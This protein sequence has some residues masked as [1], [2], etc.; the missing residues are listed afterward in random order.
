MKDLLL[1]QFSAVRPE[2]IPETLGAMLARHRARLE[3]VLKGGLPYTWENLITPLDEIDEEQNRF[4]SPVAH[5]HGTMQTPELRTAYEKGVEL[6]TAFS[7]EFYQNEQLYAALK[8]LNE[9]MVYA[10]LSSE[11][12]KLLQHTLRDFLL[13][14]SALLGVGKKRYQEISQRL[15]LLETRFKNNVLDATEA[16]E[17]RV[18]DEEALAGIPPSTKEAMRS[19]ALKKNLPGWTIKLAPSMFDAVMRHADSRELRR[20]MRDAYITRASDRGPQAGRFDN[21]AIIEEILAL[22]HEQAKLLGFKNFAEYSLAKK[23]APSVSHVLAFLRDLVVRSQPKALQEFSEL[24]NHARRDGIE[25]L[26]PW[27]L[28]YYREKVRQSRFAFSEEEIRQYFPLPKVLAGLFAVTEKLY[29]I[30]IRE[31][32]VADRPHHDV[33]LFELHDDEGTLVGGLWVDLYERLGQKRGGAWMGDAVIRW[34]TRE[35]IQK[36]VAYLTCNFESPAQGKPSLLTSSDVETL[37]HEFGHCLNH[38]LTKVE[39][40]GVSGITGVEWDAVELPSQIM[41]NWC[42]EEEV[43]THLISGHVETGHPLPRDLNE[44]MQRAKTFNAGIDSLRQLLFALYD[45]RLHAEYTPDDSA[46]VLTRWREVGDEVGVV[47]YPQSD[48]MMHSFSHIFGGGYAAG[49]YSYK[50]AEMLS[51]DAFAAFKEAGI[52]DPATAKRFLDEILSI[53]GSRSAMENFV[54]FR[55][56]APTVDALLKQDGLV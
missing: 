45:F 39:T 50:W 41:E 8:N 33:R 46:Q 15:A 14:G 19:A 4:W 48:R 13:G 17:K 44:K 42:W 30:T 54:A 26:E 6:L 2:E 38:L 1:Y 22:R 24:E 3:A 28:A 7:T 52:F 36:P 37:F 49:Y 12:K 10:T 53:G 43:L 25:K 16:W 5:L 51:A 32:V 31:R 40:R 21:R 56:R 23:M 27:D 9:G 35:G 11:Q 20:E 34:R 18:T 47:R 29:G 55:G